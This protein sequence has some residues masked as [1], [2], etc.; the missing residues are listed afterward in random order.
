MRNKKKMMSVSIGTFLV[1]LAAFALVYF[2]VLKKPNV[3]LAQATVTV[4]GHA[5]RVELA[6][7]VLEKTRGLSFR[8]SL[9]E[10]AGMYFEFGSSTTQGFWMKDMKFPIDIIW[11]RDGTVV[12]SVDSAPP[13]AKGLLTNLPI[14]YSPEP[15]THVLE[16]AAG[17]VRK[18]GIEKGDAVVFRE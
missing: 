12:G 16:V 11:I 10:D 5:F 3:G 6:K 14:Y 15:V 7:S 4:R 18:Y 1:V 13:P 2:V 9:G 8:D 17:T